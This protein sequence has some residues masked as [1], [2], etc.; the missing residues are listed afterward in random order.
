MVQDL[1]TPRLGFAQMQVE[2]TSS[3][4]AWTTLPAVP[5]VT[6]R[7]VGI[8]DDGTIAA[9]GTDGNLYVYG[10]GKWTTITG[11]TGLSSVSVAD[12]N[13][14]FVVTTN[15]KGMH[16]RTVGTGWQST[17]LAGDLVTVA[18]GSDGTVWGIQPDGSV[19]RYVNE[20]FYVAS[21]AE[22]LDMITVGSDLLV[23]GTS[24]GYVEQILEGASLTRP[25]T[26]SRV[27]VGSDGALWG[28]DSTNNVYELV[29]TVLWGDDDASWAEHTDAPLLQ[30]LSVGSRY[31]IAGV[32]TDGSIR[33]FQP[34]GSLPLRIVDAL[35]M[36]EALMCARF[37]SLAYEALPDEAAQGTWWSQPATTS[38]A[39]A[40]AGSPWKLVNTYNDAAT[41]TQAFLATASYSGG[42]Y[43]MLSIRGTSELY[44]FFADLFYYASSAK[45]DGGPQV[46]NWALQCWSAIATDVGMDLR[47]IIEQ[48]S[49]GGVRLWVVGHSLGGAIATYAA[50]DLIAHSKLNSFPAGLLAMVSFGAPPVGDA[51][52]AYNYANQKFGSYR[53]IN[54]NDGILLAAAAL[55]TLPGAAFVDVPSLV[56]VPA[57]G[58]NPY[59]GHKID[60][61][62]SAIAAVMG[63]DSFRAS[64]PV[65]PTNTHPAKENRR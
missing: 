23:W 27:G 8:G 64:L 14:L 51:T 52:F 32:A 3:T 33:Q 22:S 19:V 41:S 37:A 7:D 63:T 40:L 28:V 62:V 39:A 25:G 56:P 61:Y 44:D 54:P 47:R 30:R 57:F 60:G 6:A 34:G 31:F 2:P 43:V 12:R 21:N 42:Q 59:A 1:S 13:H 46:S 45:V 65:D 16:W 4:A 20:N 53:F 5:S 36:S 11:A 24:E 49:A 50:Y 15:N 38:V 55:N 48:G 9:V 29:G 10:G 58:T 17:A 18:A 26:L 35:P